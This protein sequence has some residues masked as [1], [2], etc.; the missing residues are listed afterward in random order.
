MSIFPLTAQ[1][2]TSRKLHVSTLSRQTLAD[3]GA[4]HLG[5][6]GFFIFEVL[7]VAVGGGIDVLGKAVSFEAAL[8]LADLLGPSTEFADG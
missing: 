7:D 1:V 3:A 5:E 2:A 8:R 4:S 6:E